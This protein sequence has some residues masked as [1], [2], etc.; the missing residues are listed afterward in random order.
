M[1]VAN[2]E[3]ADLHSRWT[4]LRAFARA[5]NREIHNL[6]RCPE[7]TWQQLYNRLQWEDEPVPQLLAPELERRSAPGATPWLWTRA[8]LP[9]SGALVRTLEG[10]LGRSFCFI[11]PPPYF[12]GT[13]GS[14]VPSLIGGYFFRLSSKST[15]ISV[16][17]SA[18]HEL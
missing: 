16:I 9:E 2:P 11:R 6:Q 13:C 1:S 4:V 14:G 17:V 7:L 18:T 8:P 5:L 12:G 3:P 15:T 10:L